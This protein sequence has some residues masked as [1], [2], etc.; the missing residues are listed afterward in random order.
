MIL[1]EIWLLP[2]KPIRDSNINGYQ[3][4]FI[5]KKVL[6]GHFIIYAPDTDHKICGEK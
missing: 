4:Q 5:Y 3:N 2:I 6:E 1:H